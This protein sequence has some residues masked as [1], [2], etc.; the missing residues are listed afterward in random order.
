MPLGNCVVV[1]AEASV[2]GIFLILIYTPYIKMN[3]K[4]I[5]E[6]KKFKKLGKQG[7]KRDSINRRKI[8]K[9]WNIQ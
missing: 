3:I 2:I 9:V 7:D 8:L 4:H 1:A 6:L 5:L